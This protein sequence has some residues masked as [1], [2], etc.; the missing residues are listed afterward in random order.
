[1]ASFPSTMRLG[2]VSCRGHVTSS[3]LRATYLP[4]KH[5]VSEA[6]MTVPPWSVASPKRIKSIIFSK[7]LRTRLSKDHPRLQK[8]R[9]PNFPFKKHPS[10]TPEL[11]SIRISAYLGLLDSTS[12]VIVILPFGTVPLKI[13]VFTTS[14]L[15]KNAES[16][17]RSSN[18]VV[19]SAFPSN[20]A[21]Q[22]DE[23]VT[24]RY[25]ITR[26]PETVLPASRSEIVAG[27]GD[28]YALSVVVVNAFAV[29]GR[30]VNDAISVAE[31]N[32]FFI[33]SS[34]VLVVIDQ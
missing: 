9:S 28:S 32:L 2:R 10:P 17:S 29:A 25:A 14:P 22:M 18:F 13:F 6:D 1:M 4:S 30:V 8:N 16:S 7:P 24:I 23:L 27:Y 21:G 19:N 34:N 20:V 12:M 15:R 5:I 11:R 33:T 31:T 3:P 26:L